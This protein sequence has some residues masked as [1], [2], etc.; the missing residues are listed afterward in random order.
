[1][2]INGPLAIREML[3]C[4]KWYLHATYGVYRENKM[5]GFEDQEKSLE[6]IISLFFTTLYQ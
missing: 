1:M 4:E 5:T 3:Q 2:L 6:E